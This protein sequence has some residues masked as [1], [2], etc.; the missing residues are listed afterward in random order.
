M[1]LWPHP[2]DAA[3]P[4]GLHA[5]DWE[6]PHEKNLTGTPRALSRALDPVDGERPAAT[7]DYVA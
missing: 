4:G 1:W 7:W 3:V 2:P 5:R 6:K